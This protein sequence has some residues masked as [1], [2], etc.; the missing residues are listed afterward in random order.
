MHTIIGGV[1]TPIIRGN[2]PLVT[3]AKEVIHCGR[4]EEDIHVNI[5]CFLFMKMKFAINLTNLDIS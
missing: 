4:K 5:I 1:R 2:R 3:G